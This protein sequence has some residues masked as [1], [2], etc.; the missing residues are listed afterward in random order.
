MTAQIAN[1][2]NNFKQFK[3]IEKLTLFA[4]NISKRQIHNKF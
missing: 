1:F 3:K 2:P 4:Q